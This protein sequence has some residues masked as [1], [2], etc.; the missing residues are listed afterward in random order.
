MLPKTNLLM[1]L[2]HWTGILLVNIPPV[3]SFMAYCDGASTLKKCDCSIR[4]VDC[5][6]RVFLDLNVC[7]L[8]QTDF[9]FW[10]VLKKFLE[11]SEI[12]MDLP[13]L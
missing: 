3:K 2:V 8:M 10:N 6:I 4:I 7:K 12:P 5:F 9:G 13:M 11:T 1:V